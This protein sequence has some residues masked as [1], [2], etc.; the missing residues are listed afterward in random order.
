[1]YDDEYEGNVYDNNDADR[2]ESGDESDGKEEMVLNPTSVR[3]R[4]DESLE[5]LSNLKTRKDR[6]LSRSDII[7]TLSR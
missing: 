7:S 6:S 4:I 5:M 2:D 1:M 3:E